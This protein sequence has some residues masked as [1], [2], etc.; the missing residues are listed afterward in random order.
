MDSKIATSDWLQIPL[1]TVWRHALREPNH[2]VLI[3]EDEPL[4]SRHR[5]N[6]RQ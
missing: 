2:A 4:T 6:L 1:L 5:R 3:V